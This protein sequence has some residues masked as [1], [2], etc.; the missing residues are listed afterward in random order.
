MDIRNIIT[1]VHVAEMGSFTKAANF[2]GYSQS[3][4]S[5][6][7]KQL[8]TEFGCQLFERINHSVTL[9]GKG[10][11]LLEYAHRINKLTDEM[12]EAMTQDHQITGSVRIATADSLC[13][14]LMR[15]KFVS[16]REKYPGIMLKLIPAGTE[17]MFRMI[18]CNEVDAIMTLDSHIYNTE[19][20]LAKEEKAEAFFVAGAELAARIWD[21]CGETIDQASKVGEK[22]AFRIHQLISYPFLLTECGM[23]YRRLLDDQLAAQSLEIKPVLEIGNADL[24]ADLAE[25]GAGIAV[26]PDFIVRERVTRGSLVRLPVEDIQLEIWKQV[27]YHRRKWMSKQLDCVIRHFCE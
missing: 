12:H 15:D 2:L 5:F 17:E 14:S 1:F 10:R 20:M 18:D 6:Q 21:E 11:E 25:Q 22:K 26:L 7:I 23:S 9:T 13:A 8:E 27:I 4:V 24:L 19:Y 16:F 3:T